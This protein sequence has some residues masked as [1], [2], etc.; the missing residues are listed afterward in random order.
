MRNKTKLFL[1]PI[2]VFVFGFLLV[3]KTWAG[4][5]GDVANQECKANDCGDYGMEP[6]TPASAFTCDASFVCC[7]PKAVSPTTPTTSATPTTTPTSCAD[8]FPGAACVDSSGRSGN[9]NSGACSVPT[10]S[11]GKPIS[12]SQPSGSGWNSDDLAQFNLPEASV[13]E[14]ITNILDWI[15][16]IVGTLAIIALVISGIQ[17]YLVA[18]DEKMLETA[19][20]TMRSAIIGLVVALSGYIVIQA[21]DTMLNAGYLF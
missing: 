13:Y 4:S 17:Y 6:A 18:T 5:C 19:K 2:A 14:I 10:T 9:C 15:L 8:L 16:T 12:T 1:I 3:G 7:V 20:K 11:V 21:V